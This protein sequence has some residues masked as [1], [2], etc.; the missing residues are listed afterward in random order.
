MSSK[1]S[2]LLF[3]PA[4]VL[5]YSIL[6][7]CVALRAFWA[8]L[9][10]QAGHQLE[11]S[12]PVLI[13]TRCPESPA[14]ETSSPRLARGDPGGRGHSRIS[15]LGCGRSERASELPRAITGMLLGRWRK[16]LTPERALQCS[17]WGL[18]S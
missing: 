18:F 3:C 9:S 7:F 10:H 16:T 5:S 4:S 11:N 12:T 17:A 14:G 1:V 6:I 2:F 13:S 8:A 15:G